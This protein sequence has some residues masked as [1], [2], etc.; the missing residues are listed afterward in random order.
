MNATV[1]NPQ[2]R[3]ALEFSAEESIFIPLIHSELPL[4]LPSPSLQVYASIMTVDDS[5]L[6]LIGIKAQLNCIKEIKENSLRIDEA[7]D[8]EEAVELF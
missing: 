2:Q 6:N 7:L 4:S 5:V 8:G 3:L 1:V